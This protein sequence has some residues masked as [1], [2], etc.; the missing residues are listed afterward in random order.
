MKTLITGASG[1]IGRHLASAYAGK[2]IITLDRKKGDI[3]L[4]ITSDKLE[5]GIRK[6][7]PE[8]IIHLAAISSVPFSLEHPHETFVVNVSGTENLLECARKCKVRRFVFVSS[9]Q[10][11]GSCQ[12]SPLKEDLPLR[13]D[14]PYAISKAAGE[15]L[16]QGYRDIYGIDTVIIRLFSIFGEG[17]DSMF[18]VPSI[19]R[20]ALSGG[21]IS[22]NT[23]YPVR[24]FVYIQDA[25]S[26]I[27]LLSEKGSGTYNIGSGKGISIG[28]LAD[29]IR[30]LAKNPHPVRS[31]ERPREH[32]I[33]ALIADISKLKKMG[34][35]PSQLEK[36]LAITMEASR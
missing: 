31:A 25:V 26:A 8:C 6:H 5:A 27:M 10:V 17:Q 7:K 11:Y 19:I 21:P 16:V 35:L 36:G 13:P 33:P 9:S 12:K 34:W 22:I 3:A 29:T 30:T 18:V 2:D 23:P 14:N 15:L 20:Q 4:D 24:D 32:D 1:F 28:D